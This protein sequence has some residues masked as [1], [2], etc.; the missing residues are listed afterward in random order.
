[1][2]MRITIKNKLTIRDTSNAFEKAVEERLIFNKPKWIENERMGRWNGETAERLKFY[3][4][5]DK[6]EL[7]VPRSFVRQLIWMSRKWGIKYR[8]EDR[9]RALSE[10]SFSFDGTLKPFQEQAVNNVLARDFGTLSAPTGAGKTVMALYVIAKRRQPSLIFV[11]TKKLINQ[12]VDRIE[13]F[14]GIPT[15]QVGII[16]NGMR[17]M[18]N[19]I[20]VTTVQTLFKCA[21]Q[22]K[23]H[24]GFLLVGQCHRAPSRT[25]TE[26][27]AAFDSKYMLG[28]SATP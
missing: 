7:I 13:A 12:W 23:E 28:L 4:S 9:R 19:K 5:R 24:I 25:F 10:V 16:G 3:E 27:V 22:V 17:R 18:G 8:L 14:L 20:T 26:T 21:D 1:M 11:H 15:D 6:G 2:E